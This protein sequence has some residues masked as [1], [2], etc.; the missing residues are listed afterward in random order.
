MSYPDLRSDC[1]SCM[2]LC[3]IALAF[4]A[5]DKFGH[6]KPAG[7]PCR[8]LKTDVGCQIH[9]ARLARGY[10]GC[11]DFECLGAGQRVTNEVFGGQLWPEAPHLQRQIEDAFRI[12]RAVHQQLDLLRLAGQLPLTPLQ[13]QAH[14]EL[15]ERLHPA[16]G[17][18]LPDLILHERGKTGQDVADFLAGLREAAADVRND[19]PTAGRDPTQ[20]QTTS[21]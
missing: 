2:G 1:G 13:R 6:D 8:Y 20:D 7:K 11:I 17:W 9:D 10:S 21:A 4:D 16:Q 18:N 5:G 14:L 19:K 3:C 15:V 12:L